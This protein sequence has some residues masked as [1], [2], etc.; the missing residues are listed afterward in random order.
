MIP[1]DILKEI[2]Q[3]ERRTNRLVTAFA[4][5]ARASAR[6]T[7]RTSVA[8]KT[9]PSPNS[10]PTLK[11][12]ERRAPDA[13]SFG[14]ARIPTGFRPKAQGCEARATLTYQDELRTLLRRHEIEFDERYVWD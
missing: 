8:S 7:A 2:R 4:A 14:S 10:I 3:I 1:R 6:F 12:R 11:R 13:P 9:N 5:G